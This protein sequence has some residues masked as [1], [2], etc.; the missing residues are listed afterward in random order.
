MPTYHDPVTY[1]FLQW[2]A[3][4]LTTPQLRLRLETLIARN[5]GPT[6]WPQLDTIEYEALKNELF[7]RKETKTCSPKNP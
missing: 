7:D 5:D 2:E 1:K 6:H 3:K 4:R